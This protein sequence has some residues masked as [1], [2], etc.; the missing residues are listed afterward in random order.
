[1]LNYDYFTPEDVAIAKAN[2]ISYNTFYARLYVYGWS[3]EKARTKPVYQK[4]AGLWP[5]WKDKCVVTQ[6][7]FYARIREG[8]SPEEAATTPPIPRGLR[9]YKKNPKV[10]QEDIKKAAENGIGENTLKRR[11]YSYRWPVEKAIN[12][13]IDVRKRAKK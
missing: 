4:G 13:P 3:L 6:Y 9:R 1:M 10:S 8:W 7:G 2:G 11:V 12:T 5:K